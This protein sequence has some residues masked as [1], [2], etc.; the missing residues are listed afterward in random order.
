M[1]GCQNYDPFWGTVNIWRRI[2]IGIQEVILT[3]TQMLM[4]G[5][6]EGFCRP[7]FDMK[8]FVLG[9]LRSG[10][11]PTTQCTVGWMTYLEKLPSFTSLSK[12][13]VLR[14]CCH[15]CSCSYSCCDYM[16]VRLSASALLPVSCVL[17][18]SVCVLA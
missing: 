11:Q 10:V 18:M 2:I 16:L 4:Q 9:L 3:T 14:F 15:S 7:V 6:T 5:S 1:G 8:K 13:Y 17:T 12:S